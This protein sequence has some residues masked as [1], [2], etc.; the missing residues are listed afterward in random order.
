MLSSEMTT[1][2]PEHITMSNPGRKGQEAQSSRIRQGSELEILGEEQYDLAERPRTGRLG[3]VPGA[4]G[5]P[6][7]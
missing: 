7:N 3:H 4:K 6:Q 1:H 5:K 2:R